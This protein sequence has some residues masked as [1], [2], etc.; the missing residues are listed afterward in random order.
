[1]MNGSLGEA[2]TRATLA[3]LFPE[4]VFVKTRALP[5]LGGLELDCYNEDLQLAVEYQ[6][7][8]H[9]EYVPH[10]HVGDI[11]NFHAQCAR[12]ERKRIAVEEAFVALV[13]VPYTVKPTRIRAYVRRTIEELGYDIPAV[14]TLASDQDFLASVAEEGTLAAAMLEK[15]HAVAAS[16]GGRCLS[17]SYLNCHLPLKWICMADHEFETPLASVNHADHARPRWCPECGGTRKRTDEENQALVASTG[18]TLLGIGTRIVGIKQPRVEPTFHLQC[19]AG[20]RYVTLR[21]NFAPVVDG[22]P[23]KECRRCARIRTNRIRAMQERTVRAAG[24]GLRLVGPFVPRE[25]PSAWECMAR[26]HQFEASW[27]AI[28]ARPRKCLVC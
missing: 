28:L 10:F 16:H 26:G 14:E 22:E 6:G 23:R 8:Q 9:Y 18:Y 3:E 1:M 5:W 27:D 12:D 24:F 17:E 2:I 13:E 19:P 4:H 25:L 15:A 21:T 20:H 7:I 11:A